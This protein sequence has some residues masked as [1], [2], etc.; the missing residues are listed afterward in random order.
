MN[1]RRIKDIVKLLMTAC[2]INIIARNRIRH[3]P[4][5]IMY[6]GFCKTGDKDLKRTPI[7]QFYKQL[8]YIKK[9]NYSLWKVSELLSAQKA[10]GSY[11]EN[12][13]AITIDDGYENFYNLAFPLLKEL[14]VPATIFV[15]SDLVDKNDWMWPDKFHYI[16]D[17]LKGSSNEL[18]LNV[19]MEILSNL[20]KLPVIKREGQLKHIAQEYNVSIPSEPPSKYKLMSWSQLKDIVQSDLIEIGSH[21]CTHPIMR[22]LNNRDSWYEIN[23]SKKTI[24]ERLQL[25][26]TSFCYPNG[27][28]GDYLEEHKKML[29]QAGYLCGIASHF[30]YVLKSSNIYSL[31]RINGGGRNFYK[32]VDYIDGLNY[33]LRHSL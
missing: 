22:Y 6:H 31:P 19:S 9:N 17:S 4:R 14:D 29:Q 27:Q 10:N 28:I 15:V 26:V 3:L 12:A 13:V 25:K 23:E 5:I 33:F 1:T 8:T 18:D 24:S 2:G 7:D 16:D 11:P 21:T 32:F 30:G 20:K